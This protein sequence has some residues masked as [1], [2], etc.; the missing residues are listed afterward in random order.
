MFPDISG[1]TMQYLASLERNQQNLNQT[2]AQIS[3]GIRVQQPSD[4]PQQVAEILQL[5][6]NIGQNQQI[7]TNLGAATAEVNSADSALQT[8][9][10]IL[11][12]AQ[13]LASEGA[14]SSATAAQRGILAQQVA[15]LQAELIAASQTQVNG[16]YIFSGDQSSSP[17]YQAAP[18]APEGV[19][20]NFT[21]SSTR[22]ISDTSGTAISVALTAQQIFDPRN[23]DTT[24]ATGNAFAAMNDLLTS[25]QNNDQAGIT[26]AV[27]ELNSANTYVNQQLAFY[28][29]AESRL[30]DATNLAQK[31]QTQQK[32]DLSNLR[33]T[34]QAAAAVS[35][36]QEQVQ[37][38]A[39]V[40]VESNI[41][42]MK[43]IFNYIA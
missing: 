20:Q 32:S 24:P 3:S 26:N 1:S 12:S 23:P 31:F 42:Q 36:N 15:G 40:A 7:Q 39:S 16:M 33:D 18:T 13:S 11:Q 19:Q 5:Q 14:N 9:V 8:S 2:A 25:L 29:A 22:T 4:S 34:D 41:L 17:Q 38:Q 30:S 27:S 21:D 28:G 6:A 37:E 35:L 43:N 10:N